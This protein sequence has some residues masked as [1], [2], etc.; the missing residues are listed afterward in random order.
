VF[1]ASGPPFRLLSDDVGIVDLLFA[2]ISLASGRQIKL[3]GTEKFHRGTARTSMS[4]ARKRVAI[5]RI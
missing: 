1:I 3:V 4:A 5:E 2:E